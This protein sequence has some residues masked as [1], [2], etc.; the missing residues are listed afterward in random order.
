V[1]D[2]GRMF[3]PG[4]V[5]A[6][7]GIPV[8]TVRGAIDRGELPVMRY[9]SRVWRIARADVVKWQA[10]RLSTPTGRRQGTTRHN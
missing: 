7:A 2:P 9:N 10:A 3:S 4:E 6:L 5:A 1:S 8:K